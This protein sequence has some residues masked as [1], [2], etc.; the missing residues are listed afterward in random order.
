MSL[1]R[2]IDG[3]NLARRNFHGQNLCTFT[4]VRTGC[5]YGSIASMLMIQGLK[6]ADQAIV[7]WD[8]PGGS[9]YRKELY[10]AYKGGRPQVDPNYVEDRANLEQLLTNMGVTQIAKPGIEAD[11]IIGF[12]AKGPFADDEVEIV[13]TDKDFY[14]LIDPRINVWNPYT[15]EYIPVVNGKI[16]IKEQNKTIFL[17]PH[18]VPDYKALVGDKSDN[19][20]G[21]SQFGITAAIKYFERNESIDP[22]LEGKAVISHLS[23]AA[24]TGLMQAI[25]F[26]KKFKEIATI[27]LEIGEVEVPKRPP[28]RQDVVEALFEHYEFK[29]FE[30]M[31]NKVYYLGG[32]L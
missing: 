28:I 27:N 4:G 6:P 30:A 7:V 12:L 31:G 5:I 18:Q 8:A 32:K 9:E 23:G 14:S 26:I 1:I 16:P 29:Q 3:S 15:Q 22:I 13:S 2:L 10:P 25:P 11:D 21:A 24:L 20:P 19:I 17:Y